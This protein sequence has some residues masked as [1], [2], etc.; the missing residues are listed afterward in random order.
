MLQLLGISQSHNEIIDVDSYVPLNVEW[1]FPKKLGSATYYWSAQDQSD[2][3]LEIGIN[4]TDGLI[5]SITLVNALKIERLDRELNLPAD[6]QEGLP[7]FNTNHTW[8]ETGYKIY[9]TN[10][11]ICLTKN[12][13]HIIFQSP[14]P[15][16]FHMKCR[17]ILFGADE[18]LYLTYISVDSLTTSER[19]ILE[20]FNPS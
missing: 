17:R 2:T 11:R 13:L 18:Q 6:C 7:L 15:T 12:K 5:R 9:Q 3:I 10:M 14:N 4:S 20:S 8:S 1:N 19:K 16:V